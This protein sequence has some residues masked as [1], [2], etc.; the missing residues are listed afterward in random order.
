MTQ[1]LD[2]HVYGR[3]IIDTANYP[4]GSV[5][6]I[7]LHPVD[8]PELPSPLGISLEMLDLAKFK[9]DVTEI[10]RDAQSRGHL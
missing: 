5:L 1:S 6:T 10:V 8:R 9:A 7:R 4:P 2:I 3:C